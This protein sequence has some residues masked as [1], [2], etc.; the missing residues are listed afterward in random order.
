MRRRN[1]PAPDEAG[2]TDSVSKIIKELR[3]M[4][5]EMASNKAEFDKRLTEIT[6]D[7]RSAAD[8]DTVSSAR[9]ASKNDIERI[10]R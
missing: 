8:Q 7:I 3:L 2:L 1:E 5:K 4:K 6:Q 9:T 10:K